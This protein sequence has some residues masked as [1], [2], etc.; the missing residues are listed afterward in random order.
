[1]IIGPHWRLWIHQK[2]HMDSRWLLCCYLQAA[3]KK[4][5]VCTSKIPR[6]HD[7]IVMSVLIALY[8]QRVR[9]QLSCFSFSQYSEDDKVENSVDSV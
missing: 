5:G 3:S 9:S 4:R 8:M 2:E 1:M 7:M 6:Q